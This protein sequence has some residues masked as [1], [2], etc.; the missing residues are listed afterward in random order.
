MSFSVEP[1]PLSAP[2]LDCGLTCLVLL[3][4]HHR[5]SA[6]SEQL[7]HAFAEEG[8]VFDDST[9]L[10]AAAYLGLEAQALSSDCRR[11]ALAPLP[12]IALSREGF[13][14]LLLHVDDTHVEFHDPRSGANQRLSL[15]A[16]ACRWGGPLILARPL[17]ERV[18]GAPRTTLRR[19]MP[20]LLKYRKLLGQVLFISMLLQGFALLTPLLFQVVMDKV[21]V[22]R[23]LSTLDVI[24]IGL[25]A[26]M[27]L[28]S[29]FSLLRNYLLGHTTSRLDAELSAG[30]FRHLLQLPLTW[31]QAHRVGDTQARIRELDNIRAFITGGGITA[32]LDVCCTVLF[33]AVMYAYSPLLTAVVLL[34]LPFYL[35]ISLL[36]TPILRV[37]LEQN[38]K[39]SA[40]G[41]AFL[42]ESVN[43]IATLKSLG[44]EPWLVQRWNEHLAAYVKGHLRAQQL[45]AVGQEC[46]GLIGKWAT[47]ATLWLGATL[48]MEGQLSVGQLIAFNMFA[49]RIAQPVLRLA[50][51]WGQFQQLAVSLGRVGTV[52]EAPAEHASAGQGVLSRLGGRIEFDQVRFRY[53]RNGSEVLRGVDLLIEPGEVIGIVGRSGCGKSTLTRLLL[54]LH[55]PEHGR[56]LLD[57]QDIA[58]ANVA[59]LR[60]QIGVVLQDSVLLQRSIRDNIA[61]ACPHASMAQ[62]MQAARLAGAHEFVERL[63]HGY[64][65]LVSEQ[66]RSL[67]GGQRQRLAIARALLSDP[68]LLIFDEATSALDY[69]SEALIQGHMAQICHGRTVLIIAHRLSSVRHAD[70][71][72]VM[73]RGQVVEMGS[74][75][76]LL[77]DPASFYA[78]A[79]RAQGELA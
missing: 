64:D 59:S 10:T 49:G 56:V 52:L 62:V 19:F 23:G 9:L 18:E 28:E 58:L 48:V 79:Y 7:R 61:I 69:E 45:A 71:I 74:H 6:C 35:L 21:L 47:A 51:L 70:R 27:L 16:F 30:L 11:L 68:R 66:G 60:R 39:Y 22:H 8:R 5:I 41:Q 20:T 75:A 46:I 32:V 63:P 57:G 26:V 65:T 50:Q 33:I 38:V 4:R 76:Q 54:K 40:S 1:Q 24:A 55:R 42:V 53:Q 14:L 2:M 73:D 78:Q 34:S 12:A 37:R 25:L 17:P 72:V 43:G 31:F 29:A 15:S 77:S 36:I 67:S 13:Y 44:L 3:A